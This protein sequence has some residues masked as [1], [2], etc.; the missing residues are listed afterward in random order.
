MLQ[1]ARIHLLL[2]RPVFDDLSPM[3]SHYYDVICPMLAAVGGLGSQLKAKKNG[4]PP[5]S[6]QSVRQTLWDMDRDASSGR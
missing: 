4:T 5:A 3:V 1:Y 6:N 2:I